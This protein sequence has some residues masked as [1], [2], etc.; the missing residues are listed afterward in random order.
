MIPGRTNGLHS[1]VELVD[2]AEASCDSRAVDMVLSGS[3]IEM[4][5]SAGWSSV[6][7]DDKEGPA[8]TYL[9]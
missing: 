3:K 8:T 7:R 2:V 5:T 1:C 9:E 4:S 6:V